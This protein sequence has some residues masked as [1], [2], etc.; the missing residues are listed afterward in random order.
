MKTILLTG[1]A[2]YIGSHTAVLLQ[3][4]GYEVCMLDNFS[5]AYADVPSRI[6]SI[7]TIKPICYKQ[8]LLDEKKLHNIF[9]SHKIEAVIHFAA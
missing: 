4:A 9:K 2:G 5:N 1:G 8:N 6:A 7:T 3:Q